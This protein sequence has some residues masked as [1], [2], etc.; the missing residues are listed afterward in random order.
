MSQ[1]PVPRNPDGTASG[2]C[3]SKSKNTSVNS[4][5][6]QRKLTTSAGQHFQPASLAGHME[7]YL[8]LFM[9][10]DATLSRVKQRFITTD[11]MPCK[12]RIVLPQ[13]AS[14]GMAGAGVGEL[15]S[16]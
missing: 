15:Q 14:F 6:S 2:S 11:S 3:L 9:P 5:K 4:G 1:T 13:G 16:S 12:V 7:G 10:K 8:P